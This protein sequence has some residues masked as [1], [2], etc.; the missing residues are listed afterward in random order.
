MA[1]SR[2]DHNAGVEP[3]SVDPTD[4]RNAPAQSGIPRS[5]S[6]HCKSWPGE[7]EAIW[8]ARAPEAGDG[9]HQ[10]TSQVSGGGRFAEP[11][12]PELH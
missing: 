9:Q 12:P 3:A 8:A 6:S 2:D 7:T 11:R 4:P 1:S 10:A 5:T